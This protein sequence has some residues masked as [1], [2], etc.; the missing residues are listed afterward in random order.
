MQLAALAFPSNPL[1]LPLVPEPPAMEQEE[2]RPI[3][4]LVRRFKP[5]DACG[6]RAEKFVVTGRALGG[7]VGPVR[8]Q[9][10]ADIAGLTR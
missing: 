9:R 5:R 8:K 2:P 10:E 6:R 3:R 7:A 1:P 4:R